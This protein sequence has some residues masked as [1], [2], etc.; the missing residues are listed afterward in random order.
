MDMLMELSS[1]A[2][3]VHKTDARA[4]LCGVDLWHSLHLVLLLMQ[5]LGVALLSLVYRSRNIHQA[6]QCDG[7]YP[8]PNPSKGL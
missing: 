4:Q 7:Q 8:M 6:D 2:G 1:L 5:H 3:L